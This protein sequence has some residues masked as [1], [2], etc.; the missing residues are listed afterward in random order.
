MKFQY[1]IEDDVEM[2]DLLI[3]LGTSLLVMPVAGI[4]SWVGKKCP[5]LLINR[6][7]VGDFATEAIMVKNWG[8]GYSRDVFLKG[9]CDD[10]VKDI[11]ELIGWGEDLNV[12]HKV[13][14]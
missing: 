10:G 4:P 13:V 8:G 7:L 1:L 6:E 12:A 5:R 9:D 11:C 2:C 3:V 14:S